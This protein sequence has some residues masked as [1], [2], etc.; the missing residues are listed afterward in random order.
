MLQSNCNI[1][2][3]TDTVALLAKEAR[4]FR[5]EVFFG[6]CSLQNSLPIF[7][8]C[9][10]G[11]S[12]S[13]PFFVASLNK[14]MCVGTF[15]V[16]TSLTIERSLNRVLHCDKTRR[17]FENTRKFAARVMYIS[18]V[19]SNVRSVSSQCRVIHGLGTRK[20]IKHAFS[21]F[22][23]LIKHGFLTN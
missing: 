3:L 14:N 15:W 12:R 16:R 2:G 1:L 9:L 20:T 11:K 6:A 19:F 22:Y 8:F 5:F 21:M 23:T 4:F 13:L 10:F 18:R 17:A 7:F